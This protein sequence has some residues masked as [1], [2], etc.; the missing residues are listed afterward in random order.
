VVQGSSAKTVD[1]TIRGNASEVEVKALTGVPTQSTCSGGVGTANVIQSTTATIG[2]PDAT[3]CAQVKDSS[4]NLL[5]STVVV[6]TTSAGTVNPATDSTTATGGGSADGTT[7]SILTPGTTG[8][9]GT[10]A[11]ITASSGGKTQ[12]TEVKFGGNS[13]GCTIVSDPELIKIGEA[14]KVTV[15]VTDSTDGPIPDGVQVTLSQVNP[16]SGTNVA[17]LQANGQANTSNGAAKFDI[18]ASIEGAIALGAARG[19][20]T[21]TNTLLTS[22]VVVPPTNGTPPVGDGALAGTL[23]SSG[24]GL[25][26]FGGS[27]AELSSGFGL[28]TFG[29][30]IAELTTALATACPSGAPI[31]ATSG[32]AFVGF[33]STTSLEAPNAAFNALFSA[34]IPANTPLL[35]GNC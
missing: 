17:I 2:N 4:G 21:C 31:F 24:F 30:S 13:T 6:F 18:I 34:G 5:P 27:I 26:T 14:A 20:T 11:T 1:I 23:P 7:D 25:V 33:F 10:T 16:G 35:G 19:S 32:G 8:T 22:G 9:S 12:T 29:G 15:N 28:V 3:L